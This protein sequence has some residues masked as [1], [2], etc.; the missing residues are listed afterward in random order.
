MKN[1]LNV[2]LIFG[3]AVFEPAMASAQVP[4][5]AETAT[6][7][8]TNPIG[9]GADP[10]VVRDES[11]DRYLWC[12]SKENRAISIQPSDSITSLGTEH[13]VWQSP[14]SGPYSREVWAPELHF[15]DG[16]WH[17]YFAAS[18]GK[19]ENHLAYVLKSR[20]SD[21]LGQYDLHGPLATGDGPDGRSPN[22]WAIDMTVLEVASQRYA[23]W[24]GWDAPGTDQQYLYIAPMKSPI[25]LAGPRVRLCNNIDHAWEKTET[26]DAG[27]GLNEAPQ[28]FLS[29]GKTCVVY[30]CGAS[31]L[32]TYKLGV[33][34]LVGDDPLDPASWTKGSQPVFE[35]TET[36]FGVGHSC[37]VQSPDGKQWWHAFHAKKDRRPGWSRVIR[38]QPM[39]VDHEGYPVFGKPLENKSLDRPSGEAAPLNR[40]SGDRPNIGAK[41]G[42]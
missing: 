15:L 41:P 31:W 14:E 12:I 1:V 20:T 10:W 22:V 39:Q 9:E 17:I 19:N 7:Q 33:L 23:I 25:E 26:N 6:K 11:S 18:N 30:S 35:S 4:N 21:P 42:R 36:I 16:R 2:L 24:S 37:F 5:R 32:P 27:R 13:I 28:V 29:S 3:L 40:T 34:A 8:F 38:V